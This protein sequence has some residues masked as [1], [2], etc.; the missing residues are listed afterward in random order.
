MDEG[1]GDQFSD[2]NVGV[3]GKGYPKESVLDFFFGVIG[4]NCLDKV[5]HQL[6]ERGLEAAVGQDC[7]MGIERLENGSMSR[8]KLLQHGRST[9]H[10]SSSQGWSA[11]N[12]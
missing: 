9:E 12:G 11:A 5:Q 8:C 4:P 1:V 10:Q 2:S 6:N 3:A 7:V